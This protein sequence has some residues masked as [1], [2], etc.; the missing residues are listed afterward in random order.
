MGGRN[1]FGRSVEDSQLLGD[2][3]GPFLAVGK[4]A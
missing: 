2:G 3:D 1:M 4:G